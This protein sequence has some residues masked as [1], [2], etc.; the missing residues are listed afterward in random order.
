MMS[1][2]GKAACRAVW[3]ASG[4][5]L[6]S[7]MKMMCALCV[8]VSMSVMMLCWRLSPASS[9]ASAEREVTLYVAN[10][11]EGMMEVSGFIAP[12][13]GW[14]KFMSLCLWRLIMS[15]RFLVSVVV[16]RWLLRAR[17]WALALALVLA[18]AL[19]RALAR[20]WSGSGGRPVRSVTSSFPLSS[21]LE[22][23]MRRRRRLRG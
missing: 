18:R 23:W 8:S 10:G 20:G 11:R 1:H 15:A 13:L 4:L 22:M 3:V 5:S 9:A 16:L 2:R 12:G 7:W 17:A 19:A 6:V 21:S 14:V